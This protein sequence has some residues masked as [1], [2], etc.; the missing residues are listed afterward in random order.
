MQFIDLN[1]QYHRIK[2]DVDRR[3]QCVLDNNNYIMG[4]EV[5]E[6]EKKLADFTGRKYC[7]SCSSGTDALVIPLLAYDLKKKD[8]VF[9]SSFTFFASAESVNIAGG[10][11]VFVDSDD[12]YNMNP[13][14]LEDAIVNTLKEGKLKP[15][16]IIA[17]DIFG[18]PCDYEK[19]VSVAEKY[20]LFLLEDA[21]Q[22]FGAK[23]NGKRTCGFGDVSATSF[24]PAKPLGCY[25]DGGAIFTD[26][27]TLYEKMYSIRVHGQGS[28]RYDNVRIG[29]NGRLDTIQAAVLLA[30]LEVFESEME[31]KNQIASQ[32]TEL[33]KDTFVTPV[34]PDNCFSVYAQYTL[35]AQ[36]EQERENIISEMKLSNVPIMVYYPVPMHM[37]TAYNYLGYKPEDLPVCYEYSK[38]VFSIPM[39]AYLTE[40][41]VVFIVEKLK[42]ICHR[43]I[44]EE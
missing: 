13:E 31:K 7:L 36:D 3:I 39:H 12:T 41:E 33:L 10:T 19:I 25:G 14:K 4:S 37:Q 22:G 26:D 44:N 35:L 1:R 5:I 2:E 16:G 23:F 21:A 38:R 24:F 6:L 30:K 43:Y 27:D 11:P 15:K 17:V 8:A 18:L 32:Y 29:M 42:A 34:I 28:N 20:N 40:E 9:V